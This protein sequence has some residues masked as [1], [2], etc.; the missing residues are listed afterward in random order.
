M[1]DATA[2]LKVVLSATDEASSVFSN[3]G[4]NALKAGAALTAVGGTIDAVMYDIISKG[5]SAQ[6]QYTQFTS[7]LSNS[8]GATAAVTQ[9]LSDA[10][11]ATNALGF[12]SDDSQISLA[13]FFQET[14]STTE[15]VKAN[16]TAMDLARQYNIDYGTAT[17]LVQEVIAGNTGALTRYGIVLTKTKDPLQN[18]N[19]LYG[20]VAGAAQKF[21]D[22]GAGATQALQVSWN[23]LQETLGETLLPLLSKFLNAI[24]PIILNITKWVT[25]HQELT[26][27]ILIGVGVL[28]VLLTVL[29]SI[30]LAAGAMVIAIGAIGGA[31]VAIVGGAI[32]LL[33]AGFVTLDTYIVQA[34]VTWTSLWE[35]M[36]KIAMDAWNW[37]NSNVIQP[38]DNA[39]MNLINK[40]SNS[41][42]GKAAGAVGGAIGS[43]ASFIAGHLAAGGPA[44]AGSTYLVG[45]QGPELF[46][47]STSGSIT[48]N[49]AMGG[50]VVNINGGTY[51]SE[52][53]ARDI[54]NSIIQQF[55]RVSRW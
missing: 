28:G 22:T 53:V 13:K 9:A 51:L 37:I 44:M 36:K 30:L 48:P 24:T 40:I 33:V 25:Q 19:N 29:G 3:F 52:S 45:E 16:N 12:A 31:M 55:K 41:A 15:A 7:I 35:G 34:N 1:N 27:Y 20:M 38:M 5:E 32:A 6:A 43:A 11:E 39:I 26:K 10:A 14:G 2:N 46:T 4:A 49:S 50:M 17:K 18:L 42:I 21:G 47:P 23:N 54:G 8:K